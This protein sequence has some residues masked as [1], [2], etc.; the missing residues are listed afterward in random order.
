[1][2]ETSAPTATMQVR[3][4]EKCACVRICGRANFTTSVDFKKLLNELESQGFDYFILDLTDCVLMDSTFLGVLAGFGLKAQP[5]ADPCGGGILELYHASA[6]IVD[7][8]ENLG[9]LDLFKISEDGANPTQGTVPAP[10]PPA[11]NPSREEVTRTCLEAHR[12]L[13]AVN[14]ENVA[15]FKDVT[16]FLSEN[17]K[18]MK[19]PEA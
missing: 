16:Q 1:M 12:T 14:P 6:R 5:E 18:K 17:L 9:V 4:G 11:S 19:A 8:L 3:L 10:T 13:M 7:L 2:S 15:R